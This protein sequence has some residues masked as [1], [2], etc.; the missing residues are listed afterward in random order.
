MFKR[1][2]T[3]HLVTLCPRLAC[4]LKQTKQKMDNRFADIIKLIKH[5]RT[6][7]MKSVNAEL[8]NLY[9]NIGAVYTQKN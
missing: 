3:P 2:E 8:I 1:V 6:I 4:L 9:W 5:S 7:A